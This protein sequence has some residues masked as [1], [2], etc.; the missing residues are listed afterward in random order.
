MKK[1]TLWLI[2]LVVG[3]VLF[4]KYTKTGQSAVAGVQDFAES[5]WNDPDVRKS[6]KDG[7]KSLRKAQKAAEKFLKDARR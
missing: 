5:V 6:R 7:A 4:A 3:G 2:V 1:S